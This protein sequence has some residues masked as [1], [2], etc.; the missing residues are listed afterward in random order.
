LSF[1]LSSTK[2]IRLST[3]WVDGGIPSDR[4]RYLRWEG[5]VGGS[6]TT[7]DVA[8]G[9]AVGVG[10]DSG[11]GSPYFCG[12]MENVCDLFGDGG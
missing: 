8:E 4:K 10:G 12:A 2:V 11:R 3:P 1:I 5:I 6:W 9:V 7:G